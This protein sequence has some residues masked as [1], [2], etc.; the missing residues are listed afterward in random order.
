MIPRT[1]PAAPRANNLGAL[2][3]L[4]AILVI[5]SHSYSLADGERVGEPLSRV[6]E[7]M[8]F[9]KLGVDGFFLI[10]GYLIVKSAQQSQTALA[11]L[12]KRVLRIYP[13]Y[14]VAYL[15]CIAISPLVGGDLA[16]LRANEMLAGVVFMYPPEVAGS[17]AGTP[18]PMLN[19]SM[20]T[21]AYEFRCYLLVLAVWSIGLLERRLVLLVATAGLTALAAAHAD[22]WGWF[23]PRLLPL[24]GN[25]D[26]G[27]TFAAIFGCGALFYLYRDRVRYDGRLA[28]LAAVALALALSS[29]HLAEAG[30]AVFGGYLL[31]W[32]AFKVK[33]SVLARI[34]SHTDL[35]YGIYLYAWPVQK[36]LIWVSPEVPPWLVFL[37]ATAIAGLLAYASWRLVEKPFLGLKTAL[38]AIPVVASANR[39][40]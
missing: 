13:G 10:S 38:P 15:L 7:T 28:A 21:I 17:F 24:L 29:R 5:L 37:E 12:W 27:L 2:R 16:S 8:S 3:L 6:F 14:I 23:P 4:F 32:F 18:H 25:P 19:G 9:G 40:P 20:W 1:T 35:S 26:L 31:F 33:S 11:F 34:G 36:L 22:I 39:E 30:V